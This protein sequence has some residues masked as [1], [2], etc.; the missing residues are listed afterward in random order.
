[1]K[2][3]IIIDRNSDFEYSAAMK[4]IR[5]HNRQGDILIIAVTK[6][7]AKAI[8]MK[9]RAGSLILAEGEIAGHCHEITEKSA[10]GFLVG[11]LMYLDLEKKTELFHPDH[12]DPKDNKIPQVLPPGKY[13]VIRQVEYRR[14]EIVRVQD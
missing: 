2:F 1:V 12:N 10:K 13:Q 6:I 5:I 4:P 7:P 8:T 11:D 9:R 3:K 14:K